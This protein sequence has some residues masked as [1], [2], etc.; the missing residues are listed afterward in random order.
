MTSSLGNL[1]CI[2]A[3]SCRPRAVSPTPSTI[4]LDHLILEEPCGKRHGITHEDGT[5]RHE[6]TQIMHLCHD[7]VC[8]ALPPENM[9]CFL[10]W[11][12]LLC[13]LTLSRLMASGTLACRP[14]LGVWG[15]LHAIEASNMLTALYCRA[16]SASCCSQSCLCLCLWRRT[17]LT[18][19][20]AIYASNHVSFCL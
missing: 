19:G 10:F 13:P 1:I 11:K 16:R 5:F 20:E 9:F 2:S 12:P 17:S 7:E 14:T 6:Q 8:S 4:Q 18:C 15:I 3:H